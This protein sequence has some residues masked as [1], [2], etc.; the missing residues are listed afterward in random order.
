[1]KVGPSG[2]QRGVRADVL[3]R[4]L[5]RHADAPFVDGQRRPHLGRRDGALGRH[6]QLG[7]SREL[8]DVGQEQAQ[9]ADV[10][11]LAGQG[12]AQPIVVGPLDGERAI[13]STAGRLLHVEAGGEP[14]LV[15]LG[16]ELHLPKLHLV[17]LGAV[18]RQ[19]GVARRTLQRYP[20]DR[21]ARR[22][23][24]ARP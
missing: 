21:C 7:N 15:A 4:R 2:F 11:V 1:M 5:S 22:A 13:Q 16:V 18:D 24:P 3:K 14:P 12:G 10:Q 6:G 20:T 9:E 23:L 17:D 8:A 19:M